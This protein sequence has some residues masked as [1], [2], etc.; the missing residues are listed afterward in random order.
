MKDLFMLDP[1]VI[2]F[3]HGSFGAT[4]RPVFEHYQKWQRELEWQP[5]DFLGRR[6]HDLMLNARKVV[7][8]FLGTKVENL[9]F[10]TNATLGIN[11]VA[12]SLELGPGDEVLS[13]DQEYGAMDRTFKFLARKKGFTYINRPIPVPVKSSA[14]FVEDFWKGVTPHTRV[15]F[16]SHVTSPTAMTYPIQAICQKARQG[17]ILTVIDGA[18][19]PG[20]MDIS[21]DTI[22]ADFYTGNLHKWVCGPKGSAFLFARPEVQGLVEPLVV[23]FGWDESKPSSF[24]ELLEWTGTRDISPFLG[25]ADAIQFLNDHDWPAVRIYCHNLGAQIRQQ[26]FELTGTPSLYPDSTEW[27]SQM[28]TASLADSTD[29]SALGALLFNEYHIVLPLVGWNE[30]K[31]V[32][33]SIQ[34]YNSQQEV[35]ILMNAIR[36]FMAK[37]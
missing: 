3:N 29:M 12:R 35:D 15:I 5:G 21:L 2:Y 4:P 18:H 33:F 19:A 11:I 34:A 22:G 25:A 30:H 7:A 26:L 10:V 20:Q 27:Y 13:T 31:L 36:K 6:H 14:D 23:S 37:G 32:R 24:E 9:V 8:N 28:G 1:D 17:S 16:L